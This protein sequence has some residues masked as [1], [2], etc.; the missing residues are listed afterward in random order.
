MLKVCYA[1]MCSMTIS[2]VVQSRNFLWRWNSRLVS[3][4]AWQFTALSAVILGLSFL[5][6]WSWW[7]GFVGGWFF[8]KA[9]LHPSISAHWQI[10]LLGLLVG[11]GKCLGALAWFWTV[12]PI[13]WLGIQPGMPQLMVIF[14]YW[15]TGAV[16][17][18]SG[19][20]LLPYIIRHCNLRTLSGGLLVSFGWVV[21]EIIGS[22]IFSI[23]TLGTNNLIPN[24]GFSFGYSGYLIA[25]LPL[26]ANVSVLGGV[27]AL[28]FVFSLTL[29]LIWLLTTDPKRD[30]RRTWQ[31]AVLIILIIFISNV[32][33]SS[34]DEHTLNVSVN[35]V[36]TRFDG[37][38]FTPPD[39]WLI[40]EDVVRTAVGDAFTG[41]PDYILL[42]E[43]SRYLQTFGSPQVALDEITHLAEG[44]RVV[45]VDSGRYTS[46]DGVTTLR[47]HILD[48]ATSTVI[49]FDKQ[50]LVP[51]G[52]YMPWFASLILQFIEG[53]SRL[54][55]QIKDINYEPG[56]LR[57]YFQDKLPAVIF[58]FESVQPYAA[59]RWRNPSLPLVFHPVSHGW[60]H[61]TEQLQFTLR[62]ML[63]AQALW[64]NVTIVQAGNHAPSYIVTNQGE[65][66][67]GTVVS[68]S[69]YYQILSFSL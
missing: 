51:Q 9:V 52:E 33:A 28:S 23:Y 47:A 35:V 20:I 17:L 46:I 66:Q 22:Y 64:A 18:G 3:L 69:K 29:L 44:E 5:F 58:C 31:I 59:L 41:K 26:I 12:Y 6:V 55:T 39:A 24:I 27:Y 40:K 14:F 11:T 60:F 4:S 15:L 30:L 43:D 42:P 54:N 56:P 25:D 8:Y 19:L 68:E 38:F 7:L 61:S 2:S 32:L 36:E 13:E 1:T 37:M 50:Y 67:F 63:V 48:S 10:I 49:A 16:A 57:Q 34:R 45:L 62:R 21:S 65:I 53:S